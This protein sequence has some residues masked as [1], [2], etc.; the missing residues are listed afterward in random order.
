MKSVL[1]IEQH[2]GIFADAYVEGR[3]NAKISLV[4]YASLECPFSIMQRKNKVM[5]GLRTKYGD[6]I[7]VIY[8]PVNL[9]GHVGSDEKG[10]AALCVAQLGGTEKYAKYYGTILDES[11]VEGFLY[12][13]DNLSKLAKDIGV[14]EMKFNACTTGKKTEALYNGY[15]TEAS[16]L[17]VQ[18]TPTTLII[19][20]DSLRYE[21]V[22]G[23]QTIDTFERAIDGLMV[24]K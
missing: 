13:L 22:Q 9:A 15:E 11:S 8:K 12:P 10:M 2:R 1:S 23:A 5:E 20:N 7:N 21:L 18:G 16:S 17:W 6:S 3:A 14:N 19:N 4:E 24:A